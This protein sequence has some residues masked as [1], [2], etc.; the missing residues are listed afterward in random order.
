MAVFSH[1]HTSIFLYELY[2]ILFNARIKMNKL[3]AGEGIDDDC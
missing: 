2:V 1:N 3:S